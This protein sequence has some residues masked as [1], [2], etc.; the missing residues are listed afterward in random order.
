MSAGSL[1]AFRFPQAEDAAFPAEFEPSVSF[2]V[3]S[4]FCSHAQP[5]ACESALAACRVFHEGSH[6]C[7]RGISSLSEALGGRQGIDLISVI[8]TS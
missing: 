2:C 7:G 3:G 4:S 5:S 6:R 1:S 8:D